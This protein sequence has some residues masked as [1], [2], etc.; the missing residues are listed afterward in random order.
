M[1]ITGTLLSSTACVALR[2]FSTLS[3]KW[4]DF[5]RKTIGNKTCVFI[6]PKLLSETF[7][8]SRRIQLDTVTNVQY[9][10]LHVKDM[11]LLTD[12]MKFQFIDQFSKMQISNFMKIRPVGADLFHAEPSLTVASRSFRTCLENETRTAINLLVCSF[13]LLTN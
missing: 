10:G 7:L 1:Q 5:R 3:H 6:F 4:H 12:L 9:I 11:L 13:T 2:Y 8:I